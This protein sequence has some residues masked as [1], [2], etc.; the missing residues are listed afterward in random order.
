VCPP[1]NAR[2]FHREMRSLVRD[3]HEVTLI[4]PY[5]EKEA[6]VDGVRLLGFPPALS[7]PSRLLNWLRIAR[8]MRRVPADAYQ[9]SDPELL[10]MAWLLARWTRKP[11]VYDCFEHFDE[12]ILS[13]ERIPV[14]A[15]R[16]LAGLFDAVETGIAARLTAVIGVDDWGRRHFSHVRRLIILRNLPWLEM[17]DAAAP[18]PDRPRCLMY[19]GD[20]SEGRRGI[21]LLIETLALL[22]HREATLLMVGEIDTPRTRARLEALIAERGLADRVCLV[23]AVPYREVTSHLR[24]AAVGLVPLRSIP[25]WQAA[26]PIKVFEY[27]ACGVPFVVSDMPLLRQ[28]V[29]DV[30]AGLCVEPQSARAFAEA[31]DFLLDHPDEACR[32]GENGRRAFLDEYN[33]ERESRALLDLYAELTPR[34]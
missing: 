24:Q 21:S 29:A 28:F 26:I 14:S 27:M 3:G 12:A 22:R 13:D 34:S 6:V 23:G 2:T 11:V 16:V 5:S 8:R 19:L 31:V 17:F 20:I 30:G 18:D 4:C 25:R 7:A 10:P 1:F 33:W 9:F 15:R 32:L